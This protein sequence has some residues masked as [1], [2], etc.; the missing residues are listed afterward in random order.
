MLGAGKHVLLFISDSL[1]LLLFLSF[2]CDDDGFLWFGSKPITGVRSFTDEGCKGHVSKAGSL[3]GKAV[4]GL[5]L[6]APVLAVPSLKTRIPP[7][8]SVVWLVD[9]ARDTLFVC[10]CVLLVR[11]LLRECLEF[12]KHV[13]D[14][15]Y[16]FLFLL[17]C[18][19]PY[20]V[21]LFVCV[22][23]CASKSAWLCVA[24]SPFH[25]VPVYIFRLFFFLSFHGLS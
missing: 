8:L 1:F 14:R 22:C 25:C 12:K 6:T 3:H 17:L 10:V 23:D 19:F 5:S 15:Y 13:L 7:S 9:T 24:L 18:P 2:V 16:S 4:K 20:I 21:P 11:R